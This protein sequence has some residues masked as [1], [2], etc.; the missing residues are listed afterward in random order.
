MTAILA[1]KIAHDYDWSFRFLVQVAIL[2]GFTIV[3]VSQPLG[4]YVDRVDHEPAARHAVD[5]RALGDRLLLVGRGVLPLGV[6]R[7][8]RVHRRRPARDGSGA[9]L[10]ARRH[11][12]RPRAPARVR[13]VHRH[14]CDRLRDRAAASSRSAS[15][16]FD[17]RDEW[18]I[19]FFV[20]AALTA[21]ARVR[22]RPS[23]RLRAGVAPRSRRSSTTTATI[24]AEHLST[25]HALTRFRQ[26]ATLRY[27]TRRRA[28]DG[29]RVHR[30]GA[31]VQPVARRVT[32]R[33]APPTAALLLAAMALPAL[34]LTPLVGRAHRSRVPA[35]AAPRGPAV[36]GP[37]PRLQ[38]RARRVVDP[39]GRRHRRARRARVRVRRRRDRVDPSRR[40][41]RHPAADTRAGLRRVHQLAV[42]RRVRRRRAA[43][44]TSGPSSSASTPRSR[45][46]CRSSP[47]SVPALMLYGSRF[48]ERD[49]RRMVEEL[50]EER[51]RADEERG[52]TEHAAAAG[53]QPRL[54]LRPGAGAVRRRTSTSTAARR[55][56]CS[57]R[58]ARASPRCCG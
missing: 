41:G 54:Q 34:V 13:G 26:I 15:S 55:W 12:P 6:P 48:A 52:G 36:G 8:P 32:S 19:A 7:R 16:V 42:H 43:S 9:D 49:M 21:V 17:G 45:S 47:C 56:R 23:P 30:L 33:S 29:L 37:A 40:A 10:A 28:R 20:L 2:P 58:T 11:V 4:N 18:R 51:A 50:E 57:A 25:L 24:R 53:P 44:S 22:R 3:L 46:S 27:M 38:P 14:G 1:I 35:G 5:A 39:L 31:L